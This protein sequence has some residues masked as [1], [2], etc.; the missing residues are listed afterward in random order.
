MHGQKFI[1]ISCS[2]LKE[3]V[4]E[5]YLDTNTLDD[6]QLLMQYFRK[7]DTDN[8][9]KLDGLELLDAF[10]RMEEDNHHHGDEQVGLQDEQKEKP[11]PNIEE[12]T[13][14][15]D[16]ILKQDDKD[17]DGYID[18]WEFKLAQKEREDAQKKEK[19][20]QPLQR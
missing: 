17:K 6:N 8:N 16:D 9:M 13:N 19:E 5:E 11:A 7:H 1:E 14:Y 4:K 15:V 10:I 3:H 2:H 12:L 20:S 18:W